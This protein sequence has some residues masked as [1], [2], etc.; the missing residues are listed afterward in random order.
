MVKIFQY[1]VFKLEVG[2]LQFIII[3]RYKNKQVILTILSVL[4]S[5]CV[6]T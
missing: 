6:K 2:I 1:I 4:G 5:I 3:M